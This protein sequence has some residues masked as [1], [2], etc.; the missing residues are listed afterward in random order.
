MPATG[1]GHKHRKPTPLWR[2]KLESPSNIG[3]FPV[4]FLLEAVFLVVAPPPCIFHPGHFKL[5]GVSCQMLT[6]EAASRTGQSA[7]GRVFLLG[8]H[9]YKLTCI[10]IVLVFTVCIPLSE[11]YVSKC[12]S[13]VCSRIL[14]STCL[15]CDS[16]QQ[17]LF[18]V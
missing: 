14:R 18:R 11:E 12:G 1:Y 3:V 15:V 16:S 7:S 2:L 5:Y 9:V 4:H 17:L 10:Y 13:N 8:P 6:L